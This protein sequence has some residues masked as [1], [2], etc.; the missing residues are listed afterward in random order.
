VAW[1]VRCGEI[2]EGTVPKNF[3]PALRMGLRA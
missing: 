2:V 3:P 1:L